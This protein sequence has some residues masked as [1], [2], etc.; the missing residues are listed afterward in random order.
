MRYDRR[1]TVPGIIP[2]TGA[3]L[4]G[5]LT[6][7]A[8]AT[9]ALAALPLLGKATEPGNELASQP[10]TT[11][12]LNPVNDMTLEETFFQLAQQQHQQEEANIPA[13]PDLAL[14][15]AVSLHHQHHHQSQQGGDD[16]ASQQ[17]PDPVLNLELSQQAQLSQ[18]SQRSQQSQGSS[19]SSVRGGIGG[20]DFGDDLFGSFFEDAI[21]EFGYFGA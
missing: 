9:P 1:G 10:A 15:Q 19:S 21:G 6:A 14:E 13:Q 20:I 16:A 8:P 7:L 11:S 3:E 4:A 2:T 17:E 5:P 18:Q 12:Y